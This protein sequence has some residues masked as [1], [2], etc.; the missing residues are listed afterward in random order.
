MHFSKTWLLLEQEGLLAQACLCNGLTTLRQASLGNKKGLFYS[1]FFEL[2]TGFERTMK[3]ILILDH[4]AQNQLSP[5]DD[6]FI[7]RYGHQLRKLFDGTKFVGV[8]LG[9]TTLE[10]FQPGSLEMI[11]LKFLDEFADTRGRYSNINNLTGHQNQMVA[12]PLQRW[13]EIANDIMRDHAT[14]TERKKAQL[15]GQAAAAAIGHISISLIN[16]MDQRKMGVAALHTR[17]SELE[18]A[19]RYTIYV[20]VTLIAALRELIESVS[21]ACWNVEPKLGS[22]G[23][24]HIPQMREFFD[25]AYADKRYAMRKSKWL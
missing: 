19:A 7:R 24:A 15:N 6:K 18:I 2:S 17:S 1:A 12:D 11:T 9:V 20:L 5:P 13:G 22:N 21:E 10:R 14:A 23:T 4:M 16:G 8:R 25:F 3:L